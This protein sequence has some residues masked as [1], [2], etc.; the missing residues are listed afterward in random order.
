MTPDEILRDVWLA[1]MWR[2]CPEWHQTK[3]EKADAKARNEALGESRG[4]PELPFRGVA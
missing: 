2:P 4:E 3:D 1:E